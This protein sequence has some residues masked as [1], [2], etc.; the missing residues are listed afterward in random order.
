MSKQP[1]LGGVAST[2]PVAPQMRWFSASVWRPI[3][4]KISSS[5]SFAGAVSQEWAKEHY[6]HPNIDFQYADYRDAPEGQ[7]DRVYS[8]GMFEHVG[9]KS[10]ATYFDKVQLG[11]YWCWS[12][13]AE[14]EKHKLGT[15]QGEKDRCSC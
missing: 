14:S 15:R 10:F 2:S 4:S 8:V 11:W 7:Y 5:R 3:R 1:A 13:G 12:H 9:R 6:G